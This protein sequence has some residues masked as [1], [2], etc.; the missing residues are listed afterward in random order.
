MA[1]SCKANALL[2][3]TYKVDASPSGG[4]K[5]KTKGGCGTKKSLNYL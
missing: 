4:I 5:T 2:S 3:G 1:Y